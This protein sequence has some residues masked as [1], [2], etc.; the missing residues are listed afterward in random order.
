MN[1]RG[2]WKLGFVLAVALVSVVFGGCLTIKTKSE[3]KEETKSSAVERPAAPTD[4]S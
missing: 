4:V 3:K 2:S 1:L